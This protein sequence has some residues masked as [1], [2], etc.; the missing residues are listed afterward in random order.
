MVEHRKRIPFNTEV[1]AAL[2][3]VRD[4]VRGKGV[5]ARDWTVTCWLVA[6]GDAASGGFRVFR[7]C[8]GELEIGRMTV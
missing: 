1:L 3:S 6:V 4:R 5:G 7:R 2:G 8:V